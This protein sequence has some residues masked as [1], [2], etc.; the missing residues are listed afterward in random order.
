M[1]EQEDNKLHSCSRVRF[2]PPYRVMVGAQLLDTKI[3][4]SGASVL[5][6]F[7][8]ANGFVV[9]V[10]FSWEP[11]PQIRE[12]RVAT[13]VSATWATL[14]LSFSWRRCLPRTQSNPTSNRS[15]LGLSPLR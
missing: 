13:S 14:G 3:N 7:S 6:L 2:A 10:S 11:D 5:Q 12:N 4:E 9:L 1:K 15:S 8:W